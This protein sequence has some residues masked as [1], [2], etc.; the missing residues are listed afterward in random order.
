MFRLIRSETVYKWT[1]ITKALLFNQRSVWPWMAMFSSKSLRRLTKMDTSSEFRPQTQTLEHCCTVYLLSRRHI[2]LA[3]V[4]MNKQAKYTIRNLK[5]K[6]EILTTSIIWWSE[7]P[8]FTR[9]VSPFWNTGRSS[10]SYLPNTKFNNLLSSSSL[11]SL[12]SSTAEREG[13]HSWTSLYFHPFYGCQ[14][15]LPWSPARAKQT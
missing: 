7:I 11:F 10:E 9:T 4:D 3:S 12:C 13:K 14:G 6:I 5:S 2:T 1:A 8:N 15:R